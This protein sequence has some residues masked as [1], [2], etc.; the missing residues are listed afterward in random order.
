VPS[1]GRGRRGRRA[2]C[3]LAAGVTALLLLT[4]ARCSGGNGGSGGPFMPSHGTVTSRVDTGGHG[5]PIEVC[6]KSD[7]PNDNHGKPLC[8]RF[9]R[10]STKHCVKGA[11]WP[12]CREEG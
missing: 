10:G 11:R 5:W 7:D 3:A 12:E 1:I 4:G 8:D 9:T 2:G 6:V